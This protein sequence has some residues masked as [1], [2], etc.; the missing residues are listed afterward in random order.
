MR[1]FEIFSR[2]LAVLAFFAA[3]GLAAADYKSHR[4]L[5]NQLLLTTSDGELAI[6]F[7]QPQV[8]EVHYLPAGVKQLPTFAIGT[9]PAPLTLTVAD[10]GDHLL[11]RSADMRIKIAKA[12]IKLSFYKGD[13][14]ITEEQ[15]GFF[16][17]N[18]QLGFKFR[19]TEQE[20][21]FGAGQRVLGMD[22]R[23]HRLPLYNK[24]HYGYSTESEQMYFSLAG[25]MSSNKYMLLFDNSA[26]GHI[27]LGK[28][29]A[30]TLEFSAV[31]GR[32][33][34]LVVAGDSFPE[35]I[36]NYLTVSGKP[37]LPARWTLGSYA[38]RFGYRNEAEA[39][40]VVQKYRELG[41]PLD[42]LV[43]DLY[44]FGPDIKGHMGN[45]AWDR[46]AFPQPEQ[47]LADFKAD[48]VNTI[49][50][51]EPF[52]LTSS[53]RWQEAVAADVLAKAPDGSPKTFDFY[54]G[55]TGLI[56]VFNPVAADWF[57][58]IY[59]DLA[60]QGV[61][62]V[63]GDLGEPEVHPSDTQ[64][65]L[66]SADEI[67]NAYGHRWA[68]MVYRGYKRNFADTRPF[69]M[70]RAGSLGSQ[71]YGM[72]P[73]TGDVDRS[74][75]GL[76]PQVELALQMS[77]FGFGYIHSDLGGFAGGET[78][79]PELYIRWLQYGVFQPVYRPHA[80]EHIAP[81][82][83]FHSKQV[84]DTLRPYL[85]LRYQLL[86]YL[87]TMAWQHSQT[88]MPLM[89][90]LFFLDETNR[91]FM[92]ETNSYL[93]GD[94]FLV[95]PVT[96]P[97]VRS[98]PVNMPDG[99]WFDFFSGKR[100]QGGE[101]TEVPVTIDTIPVLVKAGSFVPMVEPMAST[102]DY[103]S[104][105]LTVHYYADSS[106]TCAKGQMYEDDGS[107]ANSSENGN[108]ELLNFYALDDESGLKLE[109]SRSV[110]E[111]QGKPDSRELTVVLHNQ[112]GKADRVTVNGQFIA[113]VAQPQRFARQ[114]NVAYYDKASKQ[115]KVKTH[116]QG[117]TLQ[118]QVH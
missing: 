71:R 64:H 32:S 88:G 83:V 37:P 118:L 4:Q 5:G 100:Y 109:F 76:Q 106:V 27:D 23:G 39:R 53:K 48:G 1:H 55:N 9:S 62:G 18:N 97:G 79:D 14:L 103:S 25:V 112:P 49:L 54:F 92:D 6:T 36:D 116:W 52:V 89:R 43:L 35:L 33:A 42:A 105:K 96:K 19:L 61:A 12:P 10:N 47:M 74:W 75:G 17:S 99:V 68:E 113:I 110:G 66:G 2:L 72:V 30:D 26:T 41:L 20:K 11:Y 70:M 77:L 84:I 29:A 80:Q 81:E 21:L 46:E 44:W 73:W 101:R 8:A 57:W 34:Y 58:Q 31:G 3:T 63:W 67:H 7:F 78:F 115:L 108:Y 91:D 90:P 40:A 111:Y 28:T 114:Q 13:K 102:K 15:P 22:R 93:W 104:Q 16:S 86:P 98:W 82:P 107:S 59:K 117:E 85:N 94:A 69:I 38:S 24:A 95:A 45:L 87:Y 51:T 65:L 50:V 56:D 60:E